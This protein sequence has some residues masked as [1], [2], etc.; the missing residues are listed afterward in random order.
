MEKQTEF[1]QNPTRI[2]KLKLLKAINRLNIETKRK[3]KY[4]SDCCKNIGARD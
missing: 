2:N 1:K 4:T 3:K